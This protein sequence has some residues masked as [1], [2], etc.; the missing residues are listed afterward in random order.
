MRKRKLLTVVFGIIVLSSAV[1]AGIAPPAMFTMVRPESGG[2]AKRRQLSLAAMNIDVQLHGPLAET[3]VTMTFANPFNRQLAGDLYLPLPLGATVSGYALD[4]GKIMVDG[5]AVGKRK[6]RVVFEKEKRKRIDPG[7]IEWTKGNVFKTRVFPIPAKGSR[8]IRITYITKLD[9]EAGRA[10]YRLP[11]NIR[12]QLK[13]FK[14]RLTVIRPHGLPVLFPPVK[15]AKAPVDRPAFTRIESNYVAEICKRDFKA[16]DTLVVAIPIKA[17]DVAVERGLNG[18]CYFCI[19]Q[20]QPAK[21]AAF[22]RVAPL[23]LPAGVTVFWDASGSRGKVSHDAELKL[24]REYFRKFANRKLRVKLVVFRDV[25]EMPRTFKIVDGNAKALIDTIKQLPYDGGT[26]LAAISPSPGSV[27]TAG[28]SD[29][30]LLFSDGMDNFGKTQMPAFPGKLFAFSAGAVADQPF[31]RKLAREHGG[32]Y[33]NLA[34]TPTS[35]VL[36]AMSGEDIRIIVRHSSGAVSVLPYDVLLEPGGLFITGKLVSRS[37]V[38]EVFLQRQG[39]TSRLARYGVL[40]ADAVDGRLLRKFWAGRKLKDLLLSPRINRE[41]ITALGKK[42]S[43]V[44]PYTSLLVLESLEQYLRYDVTPPKTWKSMYD[45]FQKQKVAVRLKPQATQAKLLKRARLQWADLLKWWKTGWKTDRRETDTSRQRQTTR[46]SLWEQAQPKKEEGGLFGPGGLFGEEGDSASSGGGGGSIFAGEDEAPGSARRPPV[47]IPSRHR[48]QK[49]SPSPSPNPNL[50]PSGTGLPQPEDQSAPEGPPEPEPAEQPVP[51]PQRSTSPGDFRGPRVDL[52]PIVVPEKETDTK[53]PREKKEQ[54]A[55][56]Y[57]VAIRA[58]K[59][60]RRYAT[61]LAQRKIH[62]KKPGFYFACAELFFRD[63]QRLLANRIL[64]NLSELETE[65][66]RLLRMQ[67]YRLLEIGELDSAIA[68]FRRV[69][70]MRGEEPQSHLDLGVALGQR[71]LRTTGR[72]R[73]K[74]LSGNATHRIRRAARRDYRQAVR[75]LR[76]VICSQWTKYELRGNYYDPDNPYREIELTALIELNR[77][78]CGVEGLGIGRGEKDSPLG[79]VHKLE[80]DLRV[81]LRWDTAGVDVNLRVEREDAIASGRRSRNFTEGYGPEEFL[82]KKA[83]AGGSYVIKA[84]YQADNDVE[85]TGPITV[86]VDIYKNFGRPGETHK[87]I[88]ARLNKTGKDVKLTEVN[89]AN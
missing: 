39:R 23:P 75:L 29:L 79:K 73:S 56:S 43:L 72:L 18:D 2:D 60:D 31:L 17:G 70:A 40:A 14:C 21:P 28:K 49:R 81:V 80:M 89:F 26:Q 84:V 78:I 7:L 11:L 34:A 3:S 52:G 6:A 55:E 25:A 83:V 33:F 51:K 63:K 71:A 74:Y 47:R 19:H 87:T 88:T 53:P 35:K 38:I 20:P 42:F 10:V 69:L 41:K 22:T 16:D 30:C 8:T 66:P 77:L 64:S 1:Q 27:P 24:L 36:A 65:S 4:I 76:K 59:S 85:L 48:E 5:V 32:R 57:C 58:A 54:K 86:R 50:N 67:A 68:T 82:L 12:E 44:T 13:N 45:Q 9:F 46:K 37:A 62:G 61:Y 15:G